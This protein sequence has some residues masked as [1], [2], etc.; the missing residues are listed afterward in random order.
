MASRI[1]A[2]GAYRPRIE[3]GNTVQ[4]AEL[5]RGLAR[6]TSLN[7]GA[8]DQVIKEL[9]DQIIEYNRAGRGV[10]VEGLGTYT[11]NIGLDGS[12]D[13]QYRADTA[14]NNGLNVPN[15]FS[16]TII[17]REN[18]GKTGDQLVEKWNSDHP[19]DLVSD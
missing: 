1:K 17:N 11:P 6:A 12:F 3:Q 19:D 9:R 14:L 15:T 13:L 18:I 16:G 4:K 8:V 5:V 10:K 7:E 2:I